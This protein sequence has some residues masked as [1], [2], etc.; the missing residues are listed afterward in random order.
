MWTH[1][2]SN[3][4]QTVEVLT[5]VGNEIRR[6]DLTNGSFTAQEDD[7]SQLVRARLVVL[8]AESL[9]GLKLDSDFQQQRVASLGR[10]EKVEPASMLTLLLL[11]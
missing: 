1:T 5:S 8:L 6:A 7:A 10:A 11:Q 3:N 4:R 9:S 2:E